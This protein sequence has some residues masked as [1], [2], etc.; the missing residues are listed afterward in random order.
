VGCIITCWTGKGT[1]G[2]DWIV[3]E[4]VGAMRPPAWAGT[5]P[6]GDI[7]W[8]GRRVGARSSLVGTAIVA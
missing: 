1:G 6:V 4:E 8:T 5:I 3:D 7:E 2:G